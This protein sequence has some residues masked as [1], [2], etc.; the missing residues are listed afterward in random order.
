MTDL[1]PQLK[2]MADESM[3]RTLDAQA[4]AI[5]PQEAPLIR[6]YGLGPD[7]HILDAGCGTGEISSRLAEMFPLARVLG[8]DILDPHLDRARARFASLA[9]RLSFE[10][11]SVFE[12]S[13]VAATFD[14]T[15]CRHVIQSVPHADRVLAELRRVT[16]P[17]GWL[18]VIAEDYGMLHFSAGDLDPRDFW[19]EAPVRFGARTGTDLFVGRHA[20]GHFAALGLTDITL[21]YVIVDTLRVARETVATILEAWRDGYVE[22]IAEHTRFT[23]EEAKAYF[24][25]MLADIRIL[26]AGCGTGEISSRLAELFPLARVLGVDIL[27]HHLDLARARFA[28]L[29]PRLSFEHQSIFELPAADATYDLTV[30]RHVIQSVPHVDRV[31]TEL[32]RVTRPGGWLHVIAEDYDMLH[33]PV[34]EP[35]PRDFFHEAPALYGA[36]TGTDLFVGRHGYGH[37]TALGL[38]DITLDYVIVD[39]L[40]VPRETFATI[41]EAWRDGYVEPIA[42]Y[43][44]FTREEAKAYF[45]R[46]I[47]DIRDPRRYAVWMVPVIAGR[48]PQTG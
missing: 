11:Q 43:T 15:V 10:H 5:W 8:V 22:P 31:L 44:H 39:T 2:Q 9:P 16:R 42:E 25:R 17:G 38:I 23:R 33:F 29:A 32:R 18:H 6:R 14:L 28:P 27:D 36:K 41:L 24:E 7:I 47:A 12:L 21:D 46:M 30:C 3:V 26:D 13:A 4:R 48:V 37:F 1:N 40:R 19:H 34:S 20:Y 35:N 45:E